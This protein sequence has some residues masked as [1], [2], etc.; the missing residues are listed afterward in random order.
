VAEEEE[1]EEAEE[2]SNVETHL[3]AVAE[4]EDP[5]AQ[6]V[7]HDPGHGSFLVARNQKTDVVLYFDLVFVAGRVVGIVPCFG[8]DFAWSFSVSGPG[9]SPEQ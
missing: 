8:L 7:D 9:R 5:I 2:V 4:V 3:A 1:E 6:E